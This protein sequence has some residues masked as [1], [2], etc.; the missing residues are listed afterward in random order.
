MIPSTSVPILLT[1]LPFLIGLSGDPGEIDDGHG[2]RLG[3]QGD[4]G[5]VPERLRRARP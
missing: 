3:D 2:D 5:E 1:G 4:V